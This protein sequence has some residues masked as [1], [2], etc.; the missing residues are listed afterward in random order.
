MNSH[1]CPPLAWWCFSLMML[2]LPGVVATGFAADQEPNNRCDTATY[3]GEVTVPFSMNGD[4]V[5]VESAGDVD[6]YRLEAAAG[7]A[8]D[9]RLQGASSGSGTLDDPFL[10]FFDSHCALVAYN[11]DYLESRDSRLV[12]TI[13]ADG[14][15]VLAATSWSD[16]GFTG[17]HIGEG[18]YLLR[19]SP[20]AGVGS[21]LGRVVVAT[22]E[23]ATEIGTGQAV[24][25]YL[26]A[27]ADAADAGSCNDQVALAETTDGANFRF[28][29]D[30]YG[31]PLAVGSYL[32]RAYTEGFGFK[33][34]VGP[35]SVA[36]GVDYDVGT[37]E[38]TAPTNIGSIS[39]RVV[40]AET[41]VGL[42][43]VD[44]PYASLELQGCSE[45]DGFVWCD[46]L[47][48]MDT[49]GAG[50][51]RFVPARPGHLMA[52]DYK[53]VV[54]AEGYIA[55]D[56]PTIPQ[57]LAGEDRDVGEIPLE[58]YPIALS[59]VEPC[60]DLPSSGGVCRFSVRVANRTDHRPIKGAAWSIV[61]GSSLVAEHAGSLTGTTQFQTGNP[62]PTT[63]RPGAS[64]VLRFRF[65]VPPTVP[66]SSDICVTTL[67]GQNLHQ[68]FFNTL[69][70]T[71]FC[72]VNGETGFSL[73]PKSAARELNKPPSRR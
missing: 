32:I 57:V 49:D 51:F 65:F 64:R 21:I 17:D 3:L 31:A 63:L 33:G 39:G 19:L 59:V 4:L 72:I 43:G 44:S 15:V 36:E 34:Q 6:F 52:G 66:E 16:S 40:D 13:P 53:V 70:E 24:W 73:V 10:G 18:T 42:S 28:T 30:E 48:Q 68:P 69:A 60:E 7:A 45:E 35:F 12:I 14:S 61:H 8:L 22:T 1:R 29:R 37:I 54:H 23:P 38:I 41:G 46:F 47:D 67:F 25:V 20:F 71:Q 5:R 2:A 26:F 50:Y 62:I 9:V 27:C 56:G 55:R 58:R 11:D